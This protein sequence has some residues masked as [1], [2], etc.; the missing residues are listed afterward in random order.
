MTLEEGD[1]KGRV[2]E[3]QIFEDVAFLAFKMEEWVT[4]QRTQVGLESG[5]GL[6]I[7]IF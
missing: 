6:E 5:K 1:R 2:E 4:S 7:M 3:N